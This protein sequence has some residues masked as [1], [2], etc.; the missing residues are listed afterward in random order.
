MYN[1]TGEFIAS[2]AITMAI[3]ALCIGFLMGGMY[4]GRNLFDVRG[5]KGIRAVRFVLW[6]CAVGFSSAFVWVGWLPLFVI[7][8][9]GEPWTQGAWITY[10]MFWAVLML[11]LLFQPSEAK[12]LRKEYEQSDQPKFGDT[13]PGE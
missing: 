7:G 9:L 12:Q 1:S 4:D 6:R 5:A 11:T 3:A 10:G 13:S 2:L 8:A